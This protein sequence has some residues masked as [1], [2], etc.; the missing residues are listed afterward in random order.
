MKMKLH[1]NDCSVQAIH[2]YSEDG[3]HGHFRIVEAYAHIQRLRP[4]RKQRMSPCKLYTG[5]AKL[6]ASRPGRPSPAASAPIAPIRS[7]PASG[8]PLVWGGSGTPAGL[9]TRNVEPAKRQLRAV[10]RHLVIARQITDG[11][12]PR[13]GPR[14]RPPSFHRWLR[15][16]LLPALHIHPRTL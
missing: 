13:L 12:W 11:S 16:R 1:G 3:H 14:P 10:N 5:A 2:R 8:P 9:L 4:S 15:Q 7:R 6:A